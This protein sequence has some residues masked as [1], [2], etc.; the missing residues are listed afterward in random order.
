[1]M[2]TVWMAA[3][4]LQP[5]GRSPSIG[6]VAEFDDPR[7][8]GTLEYGPGLRL[9]FHCT[10]IT[11]GT[12]QIE[13]GT[14][15]AFTV[16][17][18][19]LGRLEARSVRPLPGVAAPGSTLERQH[20]LIDGS[21]WVA[22]PAG[23]PE[24]TP[25]PPIDVR[26]W[27]RVLVG[28]GEDG[29]AQSPARSGSGDPVPAD[30]DPSPAPPLSTPGRAEGDPSTSTSASAPLEPAPEPSV[31]SDP[32]ESTGSTPPLGTPPVVAATPSPRPAGSSKLHDSPRPD[33][34]SPI[35]KSVSGPPPTWRTPVTP[36]SPPASSEGG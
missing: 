22:E 16:G 2:A 31:G 26:D 28:E 35:A 8:L 21:S 6:N 9:G 33:F 13:V 15:V 4:D 10:A 12:R 7:G 23:P 5:V 30:R 3:G 18:G 25:A 20:E 36:K 19:R 14:V 34:W 32:S 24:A 11:D 17:A 1:M 29:P 27:E